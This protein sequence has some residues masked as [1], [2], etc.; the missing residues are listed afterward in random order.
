MKSLAFYAR[1]CAEMGPAL[2]QKPLTEDHQI[3]RMIARHP[4][5]TAAQ[6]ALAQPFSQAFPALAE[7]MRRALSTLRIN[8]PGQRLALNPWLRIFRERVLCGSPVQGVGSAQGC[9]VEGHYPCTEIFKET[10]NSFTGNHPIRL[11]LFEPKG[12]KIC[13]RIRE[14]PLKIPGEFIH[15]LIP[16]SLPEVFIEFV[17]PIRSFLMT[18]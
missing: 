12:F 5:A 3:Q 13:I 8:R 15:G 11:G 6:I 9:G 1:L 16:I 7:A 10:P 4:E 2:R 17:T 18:S 14:Q